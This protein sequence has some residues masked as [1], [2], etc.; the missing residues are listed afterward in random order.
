MTKPVEVTE[1]NF[2]QEVLKAEIP[3]LVDFGRLGVD[4]AAK[5]DR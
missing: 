1:N 5:W 2:D 4:L 3:V